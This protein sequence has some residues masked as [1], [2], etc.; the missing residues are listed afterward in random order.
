MHQTAAW[1]RPISFR[2]SM[3]I[4]KYCSVH[5]R[6]SLRNRLLQ[7]Y[8]VNDS[9]MRWI[10]T[11]KWEVLNSWRKK[12]SYV[13]DISKWRIL[14]VNLRSRFLNFGFHDATFEPWREKQLKV[15][16]KEDIFRPWLVY[17]QQIFLGMIE[18]ALSIFECLIVWMQRATLI[19]VALFVTVGIKI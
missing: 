17:D 16:K 18:G 14:G 19:F 12:S 8:G 4:V 10:V 9:T 3:S 2:R 15:G 11:V 13:C 1:P 7:V 5:L 6:M